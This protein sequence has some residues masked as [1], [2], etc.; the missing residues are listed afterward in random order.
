MIRRFL[1]HLFWNFYDYLGTFLFVGAAFSLSLLLLITS[2][3]SL[4]ASVASEMVRVLLAVLIIAGVWLISSA[5]FAGLMP[6]ALH[7]ARDETPRLPDLLRF[8]RSRFP[9][10]GL[11]VLV[12]GVAA[13][14]VVAN[15]F[16]YFRLSSAGKGTLK[17]FATILGAG[18]FWVGFALATYSAILLITAAEVP[19]VR[20]MARRAF[21]TMALTPGLWLFAMLALAGGIV[22]CLV[23]R[24]GVVFVIPWFATVMATAYRIVEQHAD[25]LAHARE[26]IGPDMPVGAYRKKAIELAWEWEYRQPRRTLR[27]LI[28]PWEY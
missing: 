3:P 7:A 13:A 21:M 25:Y 2:G 22:L 9:S 12:I 11:V 24:V 8:M 5:G 23:S 26:A 27:E 10:Y 4:V 28:K 6:F 17:T 15:E 18:F 1:Y 16:F 19:G 14:V 20:A